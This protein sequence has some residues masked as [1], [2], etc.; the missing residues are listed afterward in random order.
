[1]PDPA[2]KY[3]WR[4]FSERS[5]FGTFREWGYCAILYNS[6]YKVYQEGIRRMKEFGVDIE[7]ITEEDLGKSNSMVYRSKLNKDTRLSYYNMSV[8][9][10]QKLCKEYSIDYF[11]MNRAYLKLSHLLSLFEK[12][13]IAYVNNHFLVFTHGQEAPAFESFFSNWKGPDSINMRNLSQTAPPL[14][15]LGV[16]GD[17][18]FSRISNN[19][20][21]VIR[22]S[23]YRK[24]QKGELE[25][26]FGYMLNENGFNLKLNPGQGIIFTISA[27]LSGRKKKS[28]ELFIQDKTEKWERNAIIINK[29]SWDQYIVSKRIR[30]GATRVSFGVNWKPKTID[31]WLEIKDV[32]IYVDDESSPKHF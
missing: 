32:R 9:R 18:S 20:E 31:E 26:Q 30:D 13:K 5:S 23:P 11:I 12:F 16:R 1:M 10:L 19:G 27:R 15:L 25:I 14:T 3:G 24:G 2:H 7:K 8:N 28:T 6:D 17:F 4:D 29:A 22:V 21:N